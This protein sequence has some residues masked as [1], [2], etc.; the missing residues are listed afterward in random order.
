MSDDVTMKEFESLIE[1]AYKLKAEK[2]E[3][4]AQAEAVGATLTELQKQILAHMEAFEKESYKSKWGT[5]IAVNKSSVKIPRDPEAKAKFFAYLDKKGIKEDL[6]TVNSQTLNSFWKAERDA[7]IAA[8][9]EEF[10]MDGIDPPTMYK[11]ITMRK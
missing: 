6:L 5:I 11:Q 2:E 4:E 3:L 9:A 8:G 7:A 10:Q 1:Q